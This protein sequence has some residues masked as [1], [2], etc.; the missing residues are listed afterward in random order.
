MML[1]FSS[2]L[3]K[4]DGFKQK[5]PDSLCILVGSW[6]HLGLRSHQPVFSL[7]P[8]WATLKNNGPSIPS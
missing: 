8:V 3:I 4:E 2:S 6:K 1:R 5:I 7:S